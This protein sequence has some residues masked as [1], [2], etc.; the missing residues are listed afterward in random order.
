MQL[1]GMKQV[2]LSRRMGITQSSISQWLNDGRTPSST[3]MQM[4][5]QVLRVSL[6]WLARGEGPMELPEAADDYDRFVQAMEGESDSKKEIV[7][8][9]LAMPDELAQQLLQYLQ[10]HI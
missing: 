3:S 6:P 10:D 1:R 7:R 2:E 9:A 5:A 4:L 8:L